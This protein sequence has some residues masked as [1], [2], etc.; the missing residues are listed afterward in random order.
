MEKLHPFMVQAVSGTIMSSVTMTKDIQDLDLSKNQL[1]VKLAL[2][3]NMCWHAYNQ[4]NDKYVIQVVD[5]VLALNTIKGTVCLFHWIKTIGECML[6]IIDE[7]SAKESFIEL[8]NIDKIRKITN[9]NLS[10]IYKNEIM[11]RIDD[12]AGCK[13][14][15]QCDNSYDKKDLFE[16]TIS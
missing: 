3:L 5:E 12:D 1:K 11:T 8:D 15:E 9:N 13:G 16:F 14:D 4:K 10:L 6:D 7:K 2:Y